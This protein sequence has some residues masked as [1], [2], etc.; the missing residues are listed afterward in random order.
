MKEKMETA[1]PLGDVPVVVE[2]GIGVN[3]FEAH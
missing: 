2:T 1:F 3:W